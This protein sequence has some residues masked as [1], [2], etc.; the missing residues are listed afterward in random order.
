MKYNVN[1]EIYESTESL[2][3]MVEPSPP[4]AAILRRVRVIPRRELNENANRNVSRDVLSRREYRREPLRDYD[5]NN[6]INRAHQPRRGMRRMESTSIGVTTRAQAAAQAGYR[7][8]SIVAES[9]RTSV[10]IANNA[11]DDRARRMAMKRQRAAASALVPRGGVTRKKEQKKTRAVGGGGDAVDEDDEAGGT[12]DPGG[13]VESDR[14]E[15]SACEIDCDRRS[16][17]VGG[18]GMGPGESLGARNNGPSENDEEGGEEGEIEGA[19]GAFLQWRNDDF[20]RNLIVGEY[21]NPRDPRGDVVNAELPLDIRA[22]RVDSADPSR[23][24]VVSV[25]INVV[26]AAQNSAAHQIARQNWVMSGG[27][28][29]NAR[30]ARARRIAI[31]VTPASIAAVAARNARAQRLA[32]MSA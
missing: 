13:P 10:I 17:P 1:T 18:R 2:R 6:N 8:R 23:V 3:A 19:R 32:L 21:E 9:Y 27:A 26:D 24:M 31:M 22:D 12:D 20:A 25:G 7:G 30:D 14:E 4:V 28:A 5:N 15:D 11:R 29:R 16:T